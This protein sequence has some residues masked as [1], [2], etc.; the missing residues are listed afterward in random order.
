MSG[1][2]CLPIAQT[3]PTDKRAGSGMPVH[4]ANCP[5]CETEGTVSITVQLCGQCGRWFEAEP[6]E[7]GGD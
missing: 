7:E 2:S 5:Y 1:T 4:K 3:R 6:D